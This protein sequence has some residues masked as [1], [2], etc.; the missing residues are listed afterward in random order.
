M[1]SYKERRR[2]GTSGYVYAKRRTF[3][4]H[5]H[6]NSL[7]P[8]LRSGL[9]AAGPSGLSAEQADRRLKIAENAVNPQCQLCPAVRADA[10]GYSMTALRAFFE[11]FAI[12]SM[13]YKFKGWNNDAIPTKKTLQEINLGYVFDVNEG[14]QL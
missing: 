10:R 11:G 13:Y 5:F 9:L 6:P 7:I 4:A 3:G 2:R 1:S 14:N 12:G 8:T